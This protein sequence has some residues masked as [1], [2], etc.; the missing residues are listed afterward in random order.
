[1]PIT[2][3]TLT[4]HLISVEADLQIDATGPLGEAMSSW[5]ERLCGIAVE[6]LRR[7]FKFS[8]FGLKKKKRIISNT[9]NLIKADYKVSREN[10]DQKLFASSFYCY[11]F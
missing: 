2:M 4:T 6:D 11:P 5:I 9:F 3:M 1:M 10:D 8:E 7:R